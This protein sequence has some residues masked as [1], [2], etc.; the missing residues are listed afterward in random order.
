MKPFSY[1]KK[2]IEYALEEQTYNEADF[3]GETYKEIMVDDD[4]YYERGMDN[5]EGISINTEYL[6][7]NGDGHDVD[8]NFQTEAFLVSSDMVILKNFNFKNGRGHQGGVIHNTG[9][10]RIENCTFSDCKALNG[11]A[12]YNEGFLV[13]DKC[14]FENN[15]TTYHLGDGGAILNK[16]I[17]MIFNSNFINNH[18]EN[19]G[20]AIFSDKYLMA[21][22]CFFKRNSA[23]LDGGTIKNKGFL[24]FGIFFEDSSNKWNVNVSKKG[25]IKNCL[26]E[27]SEGRVIRTSEDL[28]IEN[29]TFR[30]CK[31]IISIHSS[32]INITDC[33][34]ENNISY[35]IDN[36]YSTAINSIVSLENCNFINNQSESPFSTSYLFGI[37]VKTKNWNVKNCFFENNTSNYLFDCSSIDLS[38]NDVTFEGN[39]FNFLLRDTSNPNYDDVEL[40]LDNVTFN[41]KSENI[42]SCNCDLQINDCKFLKHQKING[43]SVFD[44]YDSE[45]KFIEKMNDD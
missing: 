7:I 4:I 26:F 31:D 30:R 28:D 35:L 43:E 15:S 14:N 41:E 24:S 6:I 13:V 21:D 44:I 37:A 32:R 36:T 9:S 40:K 11:G 33:L 20:G 22:N 42:I 17:S 1:L 25:I 2:H 29:C 10:L 45:R 34:F 16:F 5:S 8:L 27:D 12:I 38:L 39:N 23:R 19:N 3:E 18:S